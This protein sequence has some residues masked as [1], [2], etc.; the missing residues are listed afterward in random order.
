MPRRRAAVR[1]RNVSGNIVFESPVLIG[2]VQ[3]HS[4]YHVTLPGGFEPRISIGA[5]SGMY[6]TR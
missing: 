5:T 3:R 1:L 2:I 4:L 6:L